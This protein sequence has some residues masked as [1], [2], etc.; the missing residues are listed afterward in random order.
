[1]QLEL[2]S[3]QPEMAVSPTP[4]LVL[5]AEGDRLTPP[6]TI[7][8]TARAYGAPVQIFPGMAH[9]MMLEPRWEAVAERILAWLDQSPAGAISPRRDPVLK[10]AARQMDAQQHKVANFTEKLATL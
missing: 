3:R 8:A 10:S 2:I 1:M 9:D 7:E 4:L 6:R 5:G